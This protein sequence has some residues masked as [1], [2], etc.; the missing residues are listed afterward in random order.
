MA[1]KLVPGCRRTAQNAAEAEAAPALLLLGARCTA[2]SARRGQTAGALLGNDSSQLTSH[3]DFILASGF[4]VSLTPECRLQPSVRE[5]QLLQS[6]SG[7]FGAGERI[8]FVLKCSQGI[9]GSGEIPTIYCVERRRE[10][11]IQASR[12]SAEQLQFVNARFE[13]DELVGGRHA[14]RP[15][16]CLCRMPTAENHEIIGVGDNLGAKSLAP[17]GDPPVL[18]EAVHIKVR[19]HGADNSAL[20]SSTSAASSSRHSQLALLVPLLDQNLQP[21]LEQ[22]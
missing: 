7:D 11:Y 8:H 9:A 12:D 4:A 14:A 10:L 16:Q 15:I 20:L 21:H 18:E 6:C 22:I 17:S 13:R 3:T 19:E 5:G 2:V 1:Y